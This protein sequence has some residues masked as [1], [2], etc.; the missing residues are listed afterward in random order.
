M[1]SLQKKAKDHTNSMWNTLLDQKAES[2]HALRITGKGQKI[3]CATSVG[4]HE[5]VTCIDSLVA[6]GLWLRGAEPQFLLCDQA[7]P[8]CEA[9]MYFGLPSIDKFIRHG[10]KAHLCASCSDRGKSFYQPLPIPINRYSDFL[11]KADVSLALK[12]ADEMDAQGCFDYEDKD[13]PIGEQVR[14]GVLRFFGKA[15]L[16]S[17]EPGVVN[18]VAQRYLSAALLTARVAERVIDTIQPECLI[19]HHGIYVPQGI[20]GIVARKKGIRVVNWGPSYRNTTV[21]YSHGDTYHHTFM[22]EPTSNWENRKLT[23]KENDALD[24]YLLLR[25]NG[26]GDWSWVSPDRGNVISD[27]SKKLATDIGLDLSKPAFGLLTNVLWDAQLF[28]ANAAFDNMLEWLFTTL[29]FFIEHQ[30][31]QLIVRIH[32]HEVKSGNR[33]PTGPEISKRYHALPENIIIIDRDAPFSTYSLMDLCKAVLIY[34][35]KTGVELTPFGQPV[36][37]AGEAWIRNKGITYDASSKEE[38]LSMLSK[39]PQIKPLPPE[40]IE[41]ARRY[42]FHY[43][44]RRMIPLSSLDPNGGFPPKLRISKLNDLLPGCDEGLD[45]ICAGILMENEFIYDAKGINSTLKEIRY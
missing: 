36:I 13:L 7:L 11:K 3:L 21:I 8:A 27:E 1:K 32:P 17:E 15:D 40:K 45:T 43:F 9:A 38:Y 37:T 44:F 26:K 35:T 10:P 4:S 12:T 14:A 19:A 41:R 25:R 22:N 34:G 29:D 42:A 16:S 28:Y 23:Q 33:Q 30:E 20:L 5:V 39:L 18:K 6:M 24:K 2:L 31:M